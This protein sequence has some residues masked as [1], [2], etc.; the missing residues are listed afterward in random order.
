[1]RRKSC[2]SWSSDGRTEAPGGEAGPAGRAE[3]AAA[4]ASPGEGSG[5]GGNAARLWHWGS[6]PTPHNGGRG[7]AGRRRWAPATSGRLGNGDRPS[8]RAPPPRL[9]GRGGPGLRVGAAQGRAAGR[10]RA[11]ACFLHAV[12]RALCGPPVARCRST[13]AFPLALSCGLWARAASGARASPRPP[14]CVAR[15]LLLVGRTVPRARG[16]PPPSG[17]PSVWRTSDSLRGERGGLG[18][19]CSGDVRGS[20]GL[21]PQ[22][23]LAALLSGLRLRSPARQTRLLVLTEECCLLREAH[24]LGGCFGRVLPCFGIGVLLTRE[25]MGSPWVFSPCT[26]AL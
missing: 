18:P 23:N 1:M 17:G 3:A 19:S 6:R 5:R 26:G 4:V 11:R 2:R 20:G 7:R 22:R 15:A 8:A 13:C 14:G 25:G 21:G 16:T 9:W 24:V 12:T 10:A